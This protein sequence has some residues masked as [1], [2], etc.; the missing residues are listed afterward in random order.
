MTV[1]ATLIARGYLPK[2]LP[3]SF[4]SDQFA[5]F[6]CSK[7]GRTLLAAHIPLSG[8]EC[9]RYRLA[10][11]GGS[12]RELHI[13]S[14]I[15]YG[16][17]VAVVAKHF[18]RLLRLSH[19]STFTR[20]APSF[21]TGVHR[22]IQ[23]NLSPSN[24]SRER[25]KARVSAAFI[26]KA[27]VSHF[28]PTLYTH[29]VGWAIDPK[30]RK[31]ANWRN[32]R[33]LGKQIDQALMDLQG[34]VSQ[35]IT[36]GNDVS[37][38]LGEIVLSEVDRRLRRAN[39]NAFRWYDD[40]EFACE[41]REEGQR[42]LAVL[43]TELAKFRLRLN[44]AKTFVLEQPVLIEDQWRHAIIESASRPLDS[45]RGMVAFFDN[46]FRLRAA[47][48]HAPV[49][50]YALGTLFKLQRP[51]A[52]AEVVAI[53]FITQSLLIE[54]GVA[55]KAFA[56]LSFWRHNGLQLDLQ[57]I[58]GT[59]R[60]MV[61]RHD[62]EGPTSDITWALFFCLEAGIP[63]DGLSAKR[64]SEFSDDAVALQALD[65][66]DKGLLPK[67]FARKKLLRQIDRCDPEG[68]HWLA[69][70]ETARQGHSSSSLMSAHPVY[71]EMLRKRVS[72]YRSSLPTYASVL[73]PGGAPEWAVKAWLSAASKQADGAAPASDGDMVAKLV[74]DVKRIGDV[75]ND[76][77]DEIVA[78][79]FG[80]DY[81][82]TM[83]ALDDSGDYS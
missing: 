27:D 47:H 77:F 68:E 80:D 50:L 73:H 11:P 2:E 48:P 39:I 43:R 44:T 34:K 55:Q 30:L 40:Y 75:T 63:L 52:D 20:S 46:A 78:R 66:D 19:R 59:V 61:A 81:Q 74:P 70:Y 33:L 13:P 54:P 6:A 15:G 67:G 31:R 57:T 53:S 76:S 17:L 10:V 35:G 29:A 5:A 32:Q 23:P 41:T 12:H 79:L 37:F 22:A 14:P 9:V 62:A 64:L 16:K 72:F 4:F 71:G 58:A 21:R 56:L 7:G 42:I 3:P 82:A 28:Y 24:I 83:D 8:T 49:L 51:T 18:R 65:M 60:S 25:A 36:I 69:L 38:L 1:K 26:A 45:A